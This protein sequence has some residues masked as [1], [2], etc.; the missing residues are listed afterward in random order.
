MAGKKISLSMREVDQETG[1]DLNPVVKGS[2]DEFRSN[3]GTCQRVAM[4]QYPYLL[5]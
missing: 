3:P 4:L 5:L 1:E 2:G